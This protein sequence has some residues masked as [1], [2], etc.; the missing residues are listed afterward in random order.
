M[1]NYSKLIND[2]KQSQEAKGFPEIT[3][4]LR[5]METI[6]PIK[7]E[8]SIFK[9]MADDISKYQRETNK[10]IQTMIEQQNI[11]EKKQN[12][13]AF[14]YFFITLLVAIATLVA[15]IVGIYL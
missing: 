6:N 15:T 8:N 3:K 10:I 11:Q 12:R 5:Q 4:S 1:L 7:Y 9:D 14:I 2:I 13:I